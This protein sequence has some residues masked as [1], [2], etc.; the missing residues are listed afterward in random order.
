MIVIFL[1]SI[2]SRNDVG[3]TMYPLLKIGVGP[4]P[5]ALG[6]AYVGL[7]DGIVTSHWNP[8]GLAELNGLQFFIS[9]HEWF[10]DI[11]DEYFMLGIPGFNGYFT[12]SGAYS[13]IRDVEI[14][15]ENNNPLG[16]E[17]LWS[18]VISLAYGT[19]LSKHLAV[20]GSVKSML[21]D[22]YEEVVYDFAADA[23]AKLSLSNSLQ[24]GVAVRNL[25]YKME[26]PSDLKIGACYRGVRGL[27]MVLDLT[28][29][30][31]NLGYAHF[32]VEYDINPY[33]CIRGGWRSGPYDLSELGWQTGF[34]AGF[35]IK[36]EGIKFDY[37]FVPYGTLGIT[38]RLALSGNLGQ[39]KRGNNLVINVMDGDSRQSLKASISLTGIKK[40]NF[41]TDQ[42]GK[43]M[44][45]NLGSGWIMINTF[46][47][48]YPQKFDSVYIYPEGRIE[49]NVYLYKTKSG[50]LRGLVFDAVTKKPIKA[51]IVY[52]GKAFGKMA[53]DSISGSFVVRD[54]PPGDYLL[55]V[56][57]LDPKYISQSCSLAIK[58]G[59]LTEYEFYLVKRREPFILRGINFDTGKAD[60]RPESY[61]VL[62][63]AGKILLDNPSVIVE[64]AGHTDPRE[65]S[66]TDYPSNWELSLARAEVVREYL[67]NKYNLDPSRLA[68]RGYADSQ[69]IASNDTEEGMAENRR[70]EFKIIEE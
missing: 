21:D 25:G 6:E 14:W 50:I 48:G 55:S 49:K 42:S 29:P 41:A 12:L 57:A 8:A 26:I 1:F 32:G 2:L 18:G 60:L 11:R 47:A 69:P 35:G 30:L 68:A 23:G 58:P 61:A 54:L 63:D 7:A 43:V 19:K 56:S 34:T 9:H 44:F 31:D 53:N 17:N 52:K 27:L 3:T 13:S 36:T 66:T 64:I 24:F 15:D 59:K 38:H 4:R 46:V 51:T 70:T 67:I 5:V 65:I 40:G 22:L 62:D 28:L 20:G 33:F 16:T 10:A 37:A 39:A 45:T